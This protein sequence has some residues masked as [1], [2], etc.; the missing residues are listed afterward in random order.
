MSESPSHHRSPLLQNETL[1]IVTAT[2]RFVTAMAAFL[3][4]TRAIALDAASAFS[5]AYIRQSGTPVAELAGAQPLIPSQQEFLAVN[6]E[7]A[8]S[9]TNRVLQTLEVFYR[10]STLTTPRS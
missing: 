3:P 6:M 5:V 7:T 10:S 9:G 2:R 1:E 4:Q 8:L